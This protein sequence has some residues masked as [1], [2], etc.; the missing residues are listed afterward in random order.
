MKIDPLRWFAHVI[1]VKLFLELNSVR[2]VSYNS[3]PYLYYNEKNPN[4]TFPVQD[5]VAPRT[6]IQNK[7]DRPDFIYNPKPGE[8]RVVELYVHCMYFDVFLQIES[9]R[10]KPF[11][12]LVDV[13]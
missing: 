3:Y 12:I 5:H 13:P 6:N 10:N 7:N 8:Y 4:R 9:F 1:L 11:F 2:A